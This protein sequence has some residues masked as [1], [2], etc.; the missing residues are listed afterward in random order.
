ME[1]NWRIEGLNLLSNVLSA[2]CP[3]LDVYNTASQVIIYKE[4]DFIDPTRMSE[5]NGCTIWLIRKLNEE[6]IIIPTAFHKT[7]YPTRSS[8]ALRKQ[9]RL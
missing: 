3:H 6:K 2:N 1:R 9:L 4:N 8:R 5:T 7:H